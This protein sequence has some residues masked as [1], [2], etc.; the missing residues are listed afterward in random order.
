MPHL[1][2]MVRLIHSLWLYAECLFEHFY[3]GFDFVELIYHSVNVI[4]FLQTLKS[5]LQNIF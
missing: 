3:S 1:Y 4:T 2:D 5:K